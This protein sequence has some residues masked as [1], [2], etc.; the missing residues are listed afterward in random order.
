MHATYLRNIREV[1]MGDRHVFL[2]PT[3]EYRT[4]GEQVSISLSLSIRERGTEIEIST[5]ANVGVKTKPYLAKTL[6]YTL[7][8]FL[9]KLRVPIGQYSFK[10]NFQFHISQNFGEDSKRDLSNLN[11]LVSKKN[12]SNNFHQTPRRL[13]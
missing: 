4:T 11:S 5:G 6:D 12:F 10:K 7:I 13:I 2:T 1:R 8:F 3:L 9:I